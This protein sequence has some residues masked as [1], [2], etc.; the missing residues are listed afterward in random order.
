MGDIDDVGMRLLARINAADSHPRIF[1]MYEQ[2]YRLRYHLDELDTVELDG[3]SW[4]V[5]LG[6]AGA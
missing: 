4:P 5:D 1:R 3:V 2:Q 6:E